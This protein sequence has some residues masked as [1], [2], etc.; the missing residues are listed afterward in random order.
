MRGK[1]TGA[2]LV[3]LAVAV[4]LSSRGEKKPARFCPHMITDIRRARRTR[5][6]AKNRRRIFGAF[7]AMCC[8]LHRRRLPP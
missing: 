3:A 4:L 2:L 8:F 6:L 5:S 1:K 7:A